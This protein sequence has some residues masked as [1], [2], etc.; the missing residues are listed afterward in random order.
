MKIRGVI[1]MKKI[2]LLVV[3]ICSLTLAAGSAGATTLSLLPASQDVW[4]GNSFSVDLVVGDLGDFTAPSLGGFL[5][6]IGFDSN[7]LSFTDVSFGS[8]LGDPLLDAITSVI[9]SSGSVELDETSLL[10]LF[11][12]DPA[13]ALDALQPDTFILA[14]LN[15]TGIGLGQSALKLIQ[16]QL[17]S[18]ALDD[19][20]LPFI[21]DA[22][23]T[24]ASVNVVPEPATLWLLGA[25]LVG[26]V[27]CTRKK[28][29]K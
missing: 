13:A 8:Y 1:T 21:L 11:D 4:V 9:V 20:G 3:M 10:G 7:I 27:G 29:L 24:G 12:L 15:F 17:A 25:G 22:T 6:G 28:H 16:T 23:A 2:L 26:I 5:V 18:A 14:T 19:N